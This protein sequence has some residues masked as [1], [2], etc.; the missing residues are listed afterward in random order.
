MALETQMNQLAS[1]LQ[2]QEATNARMT[3]DMRECA[4]LR[5]RAVLQEN[6]IAHLQQTLMQLEV[7]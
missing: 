5:E 3:D 6:Q 7:R 2:E 4:L 1:Q